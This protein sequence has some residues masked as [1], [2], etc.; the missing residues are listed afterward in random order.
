MMRHQGYQQPQPQMSLRT[1]PQQ[2]HIPPHQ[3]NYQHSPGRNNSY[4]SAAGQ[5]PTPS[6]SRRQSTQP[7]P[8][9][10]K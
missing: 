6:H 3:S 7:V 4:A 2:P 9:E 5:H 8:E 1:P 10:E